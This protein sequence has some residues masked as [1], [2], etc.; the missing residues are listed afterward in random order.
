VNFGEFISLASL[1]KP[2]ACKIGQVRVRTNPDSWYLD[3]P[4][5][6]ILGLPVYKSNLGTGNIG[7]NLLELLVKA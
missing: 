5:R 4:N 7:A 3:E 6:F 2:G 1:K